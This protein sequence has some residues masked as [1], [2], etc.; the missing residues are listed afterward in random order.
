MRRKDREGVKTF[1]VPL[2]FVQFAYFVTAQHITDKGKLALVFYKV[3][4]VAFEYFKRASFHVGFL[5]FAVFLILAQYFYA[6]KKT[7]S[8]HSNYRLMKMPFIISLR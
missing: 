7:F 6:V 4:D 8:N 1:G 5:R 3:A 2:A